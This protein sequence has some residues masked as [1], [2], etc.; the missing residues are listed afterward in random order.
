MV[1]MAE[2]KKMMSVQKF[3]EAISYVYLSNHPS[4]HLK[5][6]IVPQ[7]RLER[8]PHRT[9]EKYTKRQERHKSKSSKSSAMSSLNSS[10]KHHKNTGLPAA[11]PSHPKTSLNLPLTETQNTS[12][13]NRKGYTVELEHTK[14][15]VRSDLEGVRKEP[16]KNLEA[17]KAGGNMQ[18]VPSSRLDAFCNSPSSDSDLPDLMNPMTFEEMRTTKKTEEKKKKLSPK[19]KKNKKEKKKLDPKLMKKAKE[20]FEYQQRLYSP[21]KK[22][23]ISK[24]ERRKDPEGLTESEGVET[25]D[26]SAN[27]SMEMESNIVIVSCHSLANTS[28]DNIDLPSSEHTSSHTIPSSPPAVLASVPSVTESSSETAS[29][30]ETA[31]MPALPATTSKKEEE[32]L[33]KIKA[34]MKKSLSKYNLLPM[35]NAMKAPEQTAKAISDNPQTGRAISDSPQTGRAISDSPQTGRA[36]SDSPQTAKAIS[37]SPQT[38]RAISDSPQTAKAISDSPQTAK[39]ISDSPQTAKAI[40]DSPQTGECE[41][42]KTPKENT[43]Q[44]LV[45]TSGNPLQTADA[46]IHKQEK[47]LTVSNMLSAAEVPVEAAKANCNSSQSDTH[48]QEKTANIGSQQAGITDESGDH[49]VLAYDSEGNES[50][51][52]DKTVLFDSRSMEDNLQEETVRKENECVSDTVHA[53]ETTMMRTNTSQLIGVQ[54]ETSEES[55][56]LLETEDQ[57]EQNNQNRGSYK[58][59]TQD[60]LEDMPDKRIKKEVVP[61]EMPQ[62]QNCPM[63]IIPVCSSPSSSAFPA[64]QSYNSSDVMDSCITP[65]TTI[66]NAPIV[67]AALPNN[68][69]STGNTSLVVELGNSDPLQVVQNTRV[70]PPLTRVVQGRTP[71]QQSASLTIPCAYQPSGSCISGRSVTPDSASEIE[72]DKGNQQ[73]NHVS[74]GVMHQADATNMEVEDGTPQLEHVTEAKK[75]KENEN[76]ASHQTTKKNTESDTEDKLSTGI[77]NVMTLV[78]KK[79]KCEEKIEQLKKIMEK[80]ISILEARKKKLEKK[81]NNELAEMN[82]G[83]VTITSD[84]DDDDD[85]DASDKN[86]SED[87]V[88]DIGSPLSD[89]S[90][91]PEVAKTGPPPTAE[92]TKEFPSADVNTTHST[93]IANANSCAGRAAVINRGD[94]ASPC[95][96]SDIGAGNTLP[97]DSNTIITNQNTGALGRLPC[98]QELPEEKS[99]KKPVQVIK[100]I[101][102]AST[103]T[104]GRNTELEPIVQQIDDSANNCAAPSSKDSGEVAGAPAFSEVTDPRSQGQKTTRGKEKSTNMTAASSTTGTLGPVPTL[105]QKSQETAQLRSIRKYTVMPHDKIKEIMPSQA[106]PSTQRPSLAKMLWTQKHVYPLLPQTQKH[107]AVQHPQQKQQSV[108]QPQQKQQSVQQPQQ[109]QQSVQQP[110]QKQQSVQQPQQKQ[111]SVQQPQQ[112]QQ[113]V[114][115]PQQKQQSVQQPQQK[116]ESVQKPQQKQQSVQQPQQKQ[117]TVQQLQQ[118]QHSVQQPH[119]RQLHVQHIEQMQ[120]P[121][122]HT[123]QQQPVQQPQQRQQPAHHPQQRQPIQH[124]H[125]RQLLGQ[126]IEQMQQPAQQLLQRQQ[127]A[128]QQQQQRQQPLQQPHVRQLLGQQTDQMQQPAQQPQQRPQPVQQLQQRQQP[129]QQ[130]H[131]RQLLMQ[132]TEQIK[133]SV[134]QPQPRQQ[135][136]QQPQLIQQPAQQP[137]LR[138]QA[139]QRQQPAQ[140]PQQIQEPPQQALQILYQKQQMSQDLRSIFKQVYMQQPMPQ[141]GI[142]QTSEIPQQ[143]QALAFPAQSQIPHQSHL[144]QQHHI[145]QMPMQTMHD[146]AF[147]YQNQQSLQ[148]QIR[149]NSQSQLILREQIPSQAPMANQGTSKRVA[150]VSASDKDILLDL[151]KEHYDVIGDK[152]TSHTRFGRKSPKTLITKLGA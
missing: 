96:D 101:K 136:A 48:Q 99:D 88:S 29:F 143:Q 124:P 37:D 3:M 63:V 71:P 51:D 28:A 16:S 145:Q 95:D 134:Q 78:N 100:V 128:L 47:R 91:S 17:E 4:P 5:K 115:Q 1:V 151:V 13:N 31:V 32:F 39:A 130:H 24:T 76:T 60:L 33:Q 26:L 94:Q 59:K 12:L 125:V 89:R 41:Q 137:Q 19:K 18:E 68:N 21:G 112:K 46:G 77:K 6:P 30:S 144:Q 87:L 14:A 57:S 34:Q 35:D 22:D 149:Q 117:Q 79:R 49:L 7:V 146:S 43:F 93:A 107:Q 25:R 27:N 113:S 141:Q 58:R 38:G 126:Q 142:L 84:D 109:K 8:L 73:E 98:N 119:L 10:K 123:Q 135:P 150:P 152:A 108:E 92:I 70:L 66:P 121:V 129:V 140:Q 85:D 42:E 116:Q 61:L 106:S 81:I 127:P 44:R 23:V 105:I 138:Q 114:Q 74:K 75:S 56:G 54:A 147:V 15:V 9:I 132:Q 80:K 2:S 65:P 50:T 110:Q 40:S 104:F 82:K 45:S 53:E 11:S 64:P 131:L 120:H 36:I 118:N 103:T 62:K 86:D 67:N 102:D 83:T 20:A 133:Q 55:N 122:Q 52:S 90:K 111:Q 69:E 72:G 148:M 97:K 139:Q